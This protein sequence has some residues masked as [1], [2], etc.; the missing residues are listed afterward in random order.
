MT[1]RGPIVFKTRMPTS[2]QV[3]KNLLMGDWPILCSRER[4]FQGPPR[5]RQ[6][7]AARQSSMAKKSFQ[8]PWSATRG[9]VGLVTLKTPRASPWCERASAGL[10]GS[11]VWSL[12]EA[13]SAG[14]CWAW[15][16]YQGR[17]SLPSRG[18]QQ[19]NQHPN[20]RYVF[21]KTAFSRRNSR[22]AKASQ[23]FLLRTR[24]G[25][26]RTTRKNENLFYQTSMYIVGNMP[27]TDVLRNESERIILLIVWNA[28]GWEILANFVVK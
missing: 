28:I 13:T 9:G 15:W 18:K 5:M 17:S 3:H 27:S 1:S 24:N 22:S 6:R 19:A 4:A 23:I 20:A 25:T 21:S 8:G 26:A 7:I 16:L 2:C 11:P 10:M 14:Q 12:A